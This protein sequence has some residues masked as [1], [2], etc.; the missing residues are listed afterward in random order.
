MQEIEFETD[1]SSNR[2]IIE[3]KEPTMVRWLMKLGVKDKTTA[4][5]I[6]LGIIV[7]STIVGLM[8]SGIF[9]S[10]QVDSNEPLGLP[11]VNSL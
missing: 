11:I 6:L 9:S 10:S 3:Q 5:Y 8:F 2:V 4:N 7:L 1:S